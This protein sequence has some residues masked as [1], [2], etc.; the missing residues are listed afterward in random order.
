[1]R[2]SLFRAGARIVFGLLIFAVL[3]AAI[4]T[5]PP[6]WLSH[7]DQSFYLT[8]AYDLDH[9]GVFSNGVF[10]EVNSATAAPPPGMF[11][12]PLYPWLVLAMT[13]VDPRF[14]RAVD[15]SVEANH[16]VRDGAECEVYARPMH[17][18]H[19]A[20]LALG[21]TAI[22]LAAEVMFAS[23]AVFWLAGILATVALIPD[24][25]LFSFVMTESV[26]FY[27]YSLMMLAMVLALTSPRRRYVV[28]AGAALGLLCL[29]RPSFQVVA[30]VLPVLIVLGAR[31][32]GPRPRRAPWISVLSFAAA[33][34]VVV[35]P[36]LVRNKITVGRFALSEEYGAAALIHRF[37][38]DDMTAREF[39]LAFPYCLPVIGEPL[40]DRVF[41]PQAMK[42]F[43]Y[44]T[45]KS[46]FHV[47]RLNRDKL[48]E[49]HGR[50]DPLLGELIRNELRE[51]WW[52]Y[53]LV[54]V[55]LAWCG[56]LVGGLA[57]L[58]LVPL[59]AW[60]CIEAVRR[61]QPLLLL[62]AAPALVMLALHAAVAGQ[63]TRYNLI[64]IGPFAAGAAW[65][66]ARKGAGVMQRRGF[67]QLRS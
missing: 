24:A 54:S 3:A 43:V 60:A 38:F 33:F 65:L 25:D 59:F 50:L 39:V 37:A 13:K 45:P 34:L 30:P 20:L 46:F 55:P 4:L 6:K 29:A 1:M 2:D 49:A 41:G 27:L 10:D 5:Q 56:M 14:A 17:L 66:V 53:L 67:R 63:H 58:V 23:A 16:K 9:H 35:G 12:G 40:V 31:F 19:A 21:V 11:F 18:T 36:W 8:I 64:L 62:Y 52:R 22:A 15:C 57:G 44:S 28:L 61:S 26:T 42:R 7:F 51:R 47:G 32:V 48:V